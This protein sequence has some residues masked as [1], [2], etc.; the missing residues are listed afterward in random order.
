MAFL[1]FA[2][3]VGAAP[4]HAEQGWFG[5]WLDS[6]KQETRTLWNQGQEDLYVPL[7]THHMRFAYDAD[8][9]KDYNENPWGIGYGRGIQDADG[10]WRGLYAMAFL[11]SH[12]KV[13][14]IAGYGSLWQFAQLGD[15]RLQGGYTVFV[16]ARQDIL[17][18]MPLPEILPLAGV[19]YKK[20]SLMATYIPGGRN[21]GNVLFIF[22]KYSF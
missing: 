10:R 18:Y 19:N 17:H 6:A 1:G 13:E 3:A 22:S 21:N 5:D 7:H 12:N 16:T 14:P 2:L 20:L 15:L 9:I 8:K 11:D 4:A